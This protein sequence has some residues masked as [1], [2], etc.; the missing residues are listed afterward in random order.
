M[1]ISLGSL[2]KAPSSFPS[3][4][5]FHVPCHR[6][7]HHPFF[8]PQWTFIALLIFAVTQDCILISEDIC[9]GLNDNGQH[10]LIDLNVKKLKFFDRI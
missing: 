2:S 9:G 7:F 10:R 5:N 8:Y 3:T 4:I 1:F 6:P